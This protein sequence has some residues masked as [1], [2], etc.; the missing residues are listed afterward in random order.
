MRQM[1]FQWHEAVDGEELAAVVLEPAT[2]ATVI[3]MMASA[4]IVVVR[5][6]EPTTE[7]AD[8]R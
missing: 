1:A 3:A 8:D 4:L 2:L 6:A 7:T 5:G